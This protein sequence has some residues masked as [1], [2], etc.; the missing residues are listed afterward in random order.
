V[1]TLYIEL[2]STLLYSLFVWF[3][4]H[5]LLSPSSSDDDEPDPEDDEKVISELESDS[6]PFRR[7]AKRLATRNRNR[8]ARRGVTA[9]GSAAAAAETE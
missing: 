9:N 1:V 5:S 8:A 6:E 7:R 2:R 4:C 3:R